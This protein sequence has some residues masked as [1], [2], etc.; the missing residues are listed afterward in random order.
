MKSPRTR[1]FE[2]ALAMS[3]AWVRPCSD[4]WR[5]VWERVATLHRHGRL[6]DAQ[7]DRLLDRMP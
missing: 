5:A 4:A 6:T 2:A 3:R 7:V 1:R